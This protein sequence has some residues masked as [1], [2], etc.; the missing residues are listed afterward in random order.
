[1]NLGSAKIDTENQLLELVPE[2]YGRL[3]S[4]YIRIAKK[5]GRCPADAVHLK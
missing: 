5:P 1:M 2:S 3:F 4:V